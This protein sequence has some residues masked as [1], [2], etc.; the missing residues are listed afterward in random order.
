[1]EPVKYCPLLIA[2]ASPQNVERGSRVINT[3]V[4]IDI[5]GASFPIVCYLIVFM[6]TYSPVTLSLTL[7][8]I[9][10]LAIFIECMSFC[11]YYLIQISCPRQTLWLAFGTDFASVIFSFMVILG[12]NY[13]L[14]VVYI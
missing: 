1:M 10:Y 3:T 8:D 4:D 5:S 14:L 9:N 12:N 13:T 2:L 7:A 6:S 11:L